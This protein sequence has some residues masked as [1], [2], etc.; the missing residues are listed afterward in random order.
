MSEATRRDAASEGES[1]FECPMSKYTR[2]WAEAALNFLPAYARDARVSACCAEDK[3]LDMIGS[4]SGSRMIR[5][6]RFCRP[7]ATWSIQAR[8]AAWSWIPPADNPPQSRFGM[9]YTTRIGVL[10]AAAAAPT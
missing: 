4:T 7:A 6:G 5:A 10:P 2:A 8:Y 1:Q 9:L 3:Q